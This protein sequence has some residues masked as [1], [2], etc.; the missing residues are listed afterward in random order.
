[1]SEKKNTQQTSKDELQAELT[2][3]KVI[4]AGKQQLFENQKEKVERKII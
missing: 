4:L 3:L 1:M 2:E